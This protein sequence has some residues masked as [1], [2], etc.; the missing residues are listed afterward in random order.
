M[1]SR[2]PLLVRA[3]C[4]LTLGCASGFQTNGAG[5]STDAYQRS[6][7]LST[8]GNHP[9]IGRP[10]TWIA[11]VLEARGYRVHTAQW[12]GQGWTPRGVRLRADGWDQIEVY[13]GI[14]DGVVRW[15]S[16]DAPI[17]YRWSLFARSFTSNGVER[18]AS[19]EARA[20]LD[21][22]MA[23][24]GTTATRR[25]A[26]GESSAQPDPA[27]ARLAR[28]GGGEIVGGFVGLPPWSGN[29]TIGWAADRLAGAMQAE[30]WTLARPPYGTLWAPMIGFRAQPGGLDVVTVFAQGNS[31]RRPSTRYEIRAAFC[32]SAGRRAP[33]RP[34]TRSD[35]AR[36]VTALE[37]AIT[38][39]R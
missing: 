9:A 20:D 16:V 31:P 21:S 8:P 22:V 4:A 23:A 6:V 18:P 38:R 26:A 12:Y 5:L 2:P 11:D 32:D 17:S 36:L 28:C 29:L 34:G 39:P 37:D 1:L 33:P 10:G 13:A 7:V 35:A 3:A 14:G 19:P 24:L 25:P 27:E 30:G 15:E